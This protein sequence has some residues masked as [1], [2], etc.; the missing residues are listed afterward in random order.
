MAF[1]NWSGEGGG[2]IGHAI[3]YNFILAGLT[4]LI[5][6]GEGAEL[7]MGIGTSNFLWSQVTKL[8]FKAGFSFFLSLHHPNNCVERIFFIFKPV[9]KNYS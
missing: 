3:S 1:A 5:T 7:T 6:L 9:A 8:H 2:C 4:W